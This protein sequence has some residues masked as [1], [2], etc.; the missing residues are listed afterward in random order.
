MAGV[1]CLEPEPEPEP[2]PVI[3]SLDDVVE[4]MIWLK[5]LVVA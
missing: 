2:D 3:S 5:L 1:A 4:L